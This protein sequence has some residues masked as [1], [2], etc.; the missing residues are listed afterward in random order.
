MSKMASHEP[1]GHLQHKLW[2]KERESNWQFDSRPQKVGNRPDPGV[3]RRIV[4]HRSKAFEE[5]YKIASN[6]IP[7]RGLSR[8]LRAPKVSR[9]TS[10]QSPGSYKLP[11]SRESKPG[12]FQDSSLG[13]PRIKTIWM[14]VWRNNAEN[15]IWGKVVASPESRPW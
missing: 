7:I 9:V 2:L 11:K 3:C 13:V 5:S 8:E 4:T 15:T 10:S 12:Q 6:L 1:F 14:Q